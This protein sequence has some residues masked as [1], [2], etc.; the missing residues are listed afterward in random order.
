VNSLSHCAHVV[1]SLDTDGA[2]LLSRRASPAARAGEEKRPRCRLFFD[3]KMIE[4]MWG[5]GH[6]GGMVG[7][8]SCLTAGIALQLMRGPDGA[9]PEIG[10]GVQRGLA[11]M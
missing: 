5:E 11:A 2:L 8:T 7:Y 10:T 3:P 6:P 1:V 4:G 9:A